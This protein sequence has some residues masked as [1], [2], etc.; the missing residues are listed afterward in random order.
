MPRSSAAW[1]VSL[2]DYRN[3]GVDQRHCDSAAHCAGTNDR[4]LPDLESSCVF[5]DVWNFGDTALSEERVDQRLGLRPMRGSD[6]RSRV[7]CEP[8]FPGKGG[9]SFDRFDDGKRCLHIAP[10][11]CR[12]LAPCR[13]DRS[14]HFGRS[15]LIDAIPGSHVRVPSRHL[16]GESDRAGSKVSFNDPIDQSK[17]QRFRR[18]DRLSRNAQIHGARRPR[19]AAATAAFLQ[20]R[21]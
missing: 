11:L 5:W 14:V 13:E 15:Q 3:S 21:E 18:L 12:L 9:C 6:L 16:T 17:A 7:P 4:C 10:N 20:R 8:L 1:S 2:E 19:P